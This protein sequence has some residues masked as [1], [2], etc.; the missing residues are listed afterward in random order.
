M[1][2]YDWSRGPRHP[3]DQ[4]GHALRTEPSG[5]EFLDHSQ[6]WLNYQIEH[7]IFPYLPMLRYREVQPKVKALCAQS[8]IP[9]V[10][11]SIWKRFGKMLDICVANGSAPV[12][13]V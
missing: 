7:H 5:T 13:T 10:Q 1:T 2:S 9:Y 4:P 11:D 3:W 12:T 8:G 6:I